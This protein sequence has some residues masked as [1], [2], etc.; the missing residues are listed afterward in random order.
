MPDGR[1]VLLG[2]CLACGGVRS[3]VRHHIGPYTIVQ[4]R[5]CGLAWTHGAKL[6]PAE[7]YDRDYFTGTSAQKGYNDY[8]SMAPAMQRTSRARLRRLKR[9]MPRARTLLD[10]GCGPGFFVKE[11]WSEGLRACGLEVSAYAAAYG[12]DDLG[13][14]VL[15]GPVDWA[16]LDRVSGMVDVITLWDVLEH[17]AEPD[18]A[19]RLLAERLPPGGLL[20]LSTGDIRSLAARITGRRWHLFNLPEHLWFFTMPALQHLL[21]RA[22]LHVISV[23]R[24]VCWFTGEYL[25]ERLMFSAT[26]R[27]AWWPGLNWLRRV[28]L[29]CTLLDVVTV[30]ARKPAERQLRLAPP[31]PRRPRLAVVGVEPDAE[32]NG[33][34]GSQLG[35]SKDLELEATR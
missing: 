8:L 22:G 4:C 32:P 13:V 30:H 35:V 6:D 2:R 26:G 24:E 10:V 15:T 20:G 19:L 31:E 27:H 12:R 3:R 5:G 11:A 17:L 23:E 29:P 9:L 16:H 34:V 18:V 14:P 28:S 21:N 33:A 1:H 25:L 7:F